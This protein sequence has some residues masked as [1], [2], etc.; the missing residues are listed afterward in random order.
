MKRGM[1]PEQ[2]A[3]YNARHYPG[4]RQLCCQ[5]EEPTGRCCEDELCVEG[6]DGEE[7]GPL[8][9]ACY[10]A[11]QTGEPEAMLGPWD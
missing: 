6:P 7:V 11:L 1:Y 9:E 4:T 8:C 10:A 2:H 5:C 3:R